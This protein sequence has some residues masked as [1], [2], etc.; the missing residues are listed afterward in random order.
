MRDGVVDSP[1]AWDRFIGRGGVPMWHASLL[2]QTASAA[3]AEGS[4][5][6][7]VGD[8]RL[9]NNILLEDPVPSEALIDGYMG[10]TAGAMTAE[11][12]LAMLERG[13]AGMR[14]WDEV[15]GA[16]ARYVLWSVFGRQV[17]DRL[18]GRHITDGRYRHP[19][20]NYGDI[21]AALP[22]LDI[23][24]LAPL[25]RLPQH[26]VS[27]LFIDGSNHP[28][29][30]GYQLLNGLIFDRLDARDAY[31]RAVATVEGELLGLARQVSESAGRPVLLT[32]RSA[33]LDTLSRYMGANGSHR[34]ADAGLILAPLDH[35][36]GQPS[37]G[38]IVERTD[39]AHCAAVVVSAGG[40]DLSA[41]LARAFRT[42]LSI[43]SDVP[44]IN[45]ESATEKPIG[46]R[47]ETPR[48]ARLD[49]ALCV[50]R[51]AIT[52]DVMAPSVEQGPLGTPSW[53]GIAA[54]LQQIAGRRWYAPMAGGR[55]VATS[56][57]SP[58][59]APLEAVHR[60][61]SR[62]CYDAAPFLSLKHTTYFSVYDHLFSRFV[63]KA[64]VIVE[65]GVL[66]GGS[67]Y[68][69][70]QFF[71]PDAR[72]IGVDLNPDAVWLREDGFEIHIGDQSDPQFWKGFFRQ[73]GGV[74][75]LLDDG[76]HTYPQ[77]I[78]TASS[79]LPHIRDGGLLVV[80]DTHTSYMAEFGGPG[81]TSFV[82]WAVNMVHGVN[83]RFSA[84]AENH[85]PELRV[86]S[87][88]FF[89][90]IVAFHVD[91]PLATVVSHSTTNDGVGRD[92]KDFRHHSQS[93]MAD[94][95]LRAYFRH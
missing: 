73:V 8:F 83:H 60:G 31:D 66:N 19:A 16:R 59:P 81:D 67:L 25:L 75:I 11:R 90:S 77:Q 52:P 1:L 56:A 4:I 72:I 57:A 53:S 30:I 34:L 10:I 80:E 93:T 20:F 88:Q 18:A 50:K 63:G 22:G 43:W 24:D 55:Q 86:W 68:M 28:S 14:A 51:G 70:R 47:G 35:V 6:V 82:N 40:R 29:Q 71:G 33:W 78:V 58:D 41:V 45:W 79:A 95:D 46:D 49:P 87:V 64:P 54:L 27:R 76:G 23:V 17:H 2:R 38:Q 42:G 48:F 39:L 15:F 21:A 5:A 36:P 37:L 26:E 61:R 84:F 62:A 89:E 44:V 94:D 9:G 12:D 65:V 32:G 92:A 91:R 7:L 3:G 69:W 85:D 13:L 74:D